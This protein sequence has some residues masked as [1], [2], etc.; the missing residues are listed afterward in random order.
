MKKLLFVLMTAVSVYAVVTISSCKKDDTTPPVITV[1]GDN[2]A[3][4]V[5]GH[6]YSDAGATANDAED[7]NVSVS[8]S[9]TVDVNTAGTY[10]INYSAADAAG[11]QATA[12]RTVN[13]VIARENYV[14]AAYTAD[15]SST[16]NSTIG[17]FTY[18]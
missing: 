5:L 10:S 17:A 11:N 14:W 9:G 2:P 12:S 4:V 6:T 8:S 1:S 3:T 7:G 13:V 16:T 15:D 18:L